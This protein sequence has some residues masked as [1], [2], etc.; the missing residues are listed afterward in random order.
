MRNLELL[1][2]KLQSSQKVI[3]VPHRRPDADA[4]GSCLA[5]S[6]YLQKKGHETLVISPDEYPQFL[7]WMTGNEQVAIYENGNQAELN[8]KINEADLIFC[9]DFSSLDRIEKL[10]EPIAKSPAEKVL[11]DHHLGK[12]DFAKYE[13]WDTKASATA[14]L[15]FDFITLLGDQKMIDVEIAE[16]IYAGIMTD[17]GSFKYSSTSSK[18]HRNIAVLMDRGLNTER[19]HRLV[20]DTNSENRIRFLG[21]ALDNRLEIIREYNTAFIYIKAEDLK[22]FNSKTGDTEGLVNYA[23]SIEGI[24][25]A[26]MFT[27]RNDGISMSFRSVGDFSVSELAAKHFNGGGHKNAAGGRLDIPLEDV[28]KKFKEVLKE[29]EAALKA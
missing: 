14:E 10:G 17:T 7:F 4:L 3:I 21:F 15:I 12:E 2:E 11:I 29:Y 26:A 18:V 23:L 19:I 1:K 9:L 6:M 25:L 20:Y 5:L 24:K 13:L 16:C 8:K 22:R 28:I 27:D